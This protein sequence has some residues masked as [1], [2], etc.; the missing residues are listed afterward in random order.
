MKKFNVSL[1]KTKQNNTEK[2][3]K[4]T[5]RRAV[6]FSIILLLVVSTFGLLLL[7]DTTRASTTT[8]HHQWIVYVGG[9]SSDM[10]VMTMGFYPEI[11]T[12]DAGDSITF[13]VNST[14]PHTVTFL[15]GNPPLNPFLPQSLLPMG[16]SIYNGTGIVSSGL[17]FPGQTYTLT[18]TTPGVYIYQCT[19]HPGMVGVVIVNPAGTPYPLNQSQYD[20]IA[21]L[22]NLQALQ[23]GESLLQ[24]VNLPATPGPNGTLIWHIDA[25]FETPVS[26][27][28]TLN[29][30]NSN[31]NGLAILSMAIPGELT[32]Q[33]SLS[34]LTPGKTY[35]VGIYEGAAEVGGN[36][37]YNLSPITASSN[38]TG[39][40]L[41]TLK[42][43]PLSPYIP[44]SFGIPAAGW[45]INV[46]S[47]GGAVATGDVIVPSASVMRFL[48]TTLTIH[49]GDTV[50]WTQLDP[51]EI[52]TITFVPQG[53]PIPEFGTPLSLIPS[54]GHLF[55]GSGY[56]NSGPL[57]AGQSYNLTFLTPGVYTYVCTLH[58]GMGMVG[59]IIVLP[60]DVQLSSHQI[61]EL[62]KTLT[63]VWYNVSGQL[64]FLNSQLTS[65]SG[66][67]SSINGQISQLGSLGNELTSL[68]NSQVA[69]Q[70]NVNGKISSLYTLIAVL[71]A[72][73]VI[74]LIMNVIIMTRKR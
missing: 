50:V 66:K 7:S 62:N 30:V 52:H 34:G 41:T 27:E 60:N 29:P 53:M 73:V 42:I 49:V 47:S 40:S 39:V 33:V 57:I 21:Y 23:S 68:N 58:D 43:P 56:Y 1:R 20:Q 59:T 72:L 67:I 25:G 74:S 13:I 12:I 18:F 6:N 65:L 35:K 36:V 22:Q 19:I 54:G 63:N 44:T 70:N 61:S 4:N 10:S 69:Y 51:A 9:Q 55:N 14:E 38:G 16:G 11:I 24:Q 17:L 46:S 15:S 48:P 71:L 64:L 31:V 32:V 37:L 3:N 45:Y 28:V 5:K 8:A 26:T 2:C